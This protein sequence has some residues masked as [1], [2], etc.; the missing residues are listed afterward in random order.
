MEESQRLEALLIKIKLAIDHEDMFDVIHG[1]MQ[2][3]FPE[4]NDVNGSLFKEAR[5]YMGEKKM[6]PKYQEQNLSLYNEFIKDF[7]SFISDKIIRIKYSTCDP[8]K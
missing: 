5:V 2:S 1:L 4:A 7:A 3:E 6:H 8:H